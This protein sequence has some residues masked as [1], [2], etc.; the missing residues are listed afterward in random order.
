[1]EE[2]NLS[3]FTSNYYSPLGRL[4]LV[5][6]GKT[7]VG[8][9]FEKQKNF[10]YQLDKKENKRD[11]LF[12]FKES[13]KWL[14]LYFSEKEPNFFPEITLTGTDFQKEIYKLLLNIPF[15]ETVFYSQLATE[16]AKRRKLPK[17][18]AQ[19]IGQAV[20]KNKICII[21]PC[22]RV[23]GK[24]DFLTGYQAGVYRKEILLELEKRIKNKRS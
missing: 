5:S 7:L 23:I 20:A 11:S 8:C 3:L 14:D 19:A 18:S 24:E 10:P 9:F 12:C 21:V 2:N 22:H 6:E 15:A 17:F 4:L 1:M 16:I 13:K